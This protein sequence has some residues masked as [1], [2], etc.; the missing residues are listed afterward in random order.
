MFGGDRLAFDEPTRRAHG[1]DKWFAEHDPDVVV[2][3]E[4]TEDVSRLMRFATE[5]KSR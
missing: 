1:G 3:A 5:H 4:S 2:F